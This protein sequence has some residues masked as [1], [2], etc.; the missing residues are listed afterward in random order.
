MES[1]FSKIS[2][3]MKKT[4]KIE[5]ENVKENEEET[6]LSGKEWIQSKG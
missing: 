4:L 1:L 3:F 6:K 5:F 2:N